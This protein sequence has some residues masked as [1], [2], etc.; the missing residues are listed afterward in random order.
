MFLCDSI[1]PFFLFYNWKKS[2]LYVKKVYFKGKIFKIE[3]CKRFIIKN[4]FKPSK[5]ELKGAEQNMLFLTG[6]CF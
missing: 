2:N 1:F 3:V 4:T 6:F 5:A